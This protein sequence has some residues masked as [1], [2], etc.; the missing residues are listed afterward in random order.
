M[1]RQNDGGRP[2]D[3]YGRHGECDRHCDHVHF[4]DVHAHVCGGHGQL[5]D[6][7]GPLFGEPCHPCDD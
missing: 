4:C 7:H 3:D 6:A 5:Y 2:H 1:M